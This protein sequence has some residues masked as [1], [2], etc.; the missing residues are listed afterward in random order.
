[1]RKCARA[2]GEICPPGEIVARVPALRALE[3][4]FEKVRRPLQTCVKEARFCSLSRCSPVSTGMGSPAMPASRSTAS[5][6]EI[7]SVSIRKVEA[8]AVL[9]RREVVEK[10][11][12][13]R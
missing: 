9:A 11:S 3:L 6:K 1:M 13:G 4:L 12:F 8:V 5:G 10:A 2:A 7:P